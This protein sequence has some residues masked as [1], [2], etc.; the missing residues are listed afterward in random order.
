MVQHSE[1]TCGKSSVLSIQIFGGWGKSQ[2]T[3]LQGSYTF[4]YGGIWRGYLG[5]ELI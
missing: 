2:M 1:L 3:V 4:Y 5:N